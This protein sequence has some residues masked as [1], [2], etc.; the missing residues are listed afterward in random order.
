MPQST[1]NK[2]LQAFVLAEG[3]TKGGFAHGAGK[4]IESGAFGEKAAFEAEL[5]EKNRAYSVT[6][7]TVILALARAM[8]LRLKPMTAGEALSG[9]SSFST[10]RAQTV[11][12]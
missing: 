8:A 5:H 1:E 2:K 10:G 7:V 6:H 12:T 4:K 11:K 3:R 9:T